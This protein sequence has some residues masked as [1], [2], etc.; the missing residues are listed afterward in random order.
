[1]K[2]SYS[3]GMAF[4]L[5][6]FGSIGIATLLTSV[7]T[8]RIYGVT[9]VGQ[10]ALAL[11]PVMVVTLLSTVREQPAMVRK[12]AKLEPR[13]PAVTGIWLAVFCFSFALT[14]VVAALGVVACWFV[15][16]GPI[17]EPQLFAPAAVALAGYLLVINTCWNV[18][19]AL[20]AFRAGREL[21]EVRLHQALMYGALV[22]AFSFVDEG[23]WSLTLA[24]LVSWATSLVHRCALVPRVMRLRVPRAQLREGFAELREIVGFGLKITP[25]SIANGLSDASGTWI[26]GVTSSV[27]AVGAFSRAWNVS[28]RFGEL[29][30]RVT[31]M[32]LP[33]L[34]ERRA[35]GD[36]EGTHRVVGDSLRY[37][38]FGML[39]P[40]AVG[41]GAAHAV[42]QLFGSGFAPAASALCWLLL[43]PWLQTM[44]A[45]QGSVLMAYNRPVWT[46]FAQG[47]RLL[48]TLTA[49][50][51]LTLAIG[52]T[53][54][55]VAIVGGCLASFGV[56]LVI[57]RTLAVLPPPPL[58]RLARLLAGIG[59]A[60]AAGFFGARTIE[61]H[62][63]WPL[64]LPLALLGGTAAF[65]LAALAVAG[66][67]ARDRE[68]L[69]ALWRL[70][71][72]R[73]ADRR[74]RGGSLRSNAAAGAEDVAQ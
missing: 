5:A 3:S 40:A 10:A 62:V 49:G 28:S 51:L 2:R 13:D 26:L 69:R 35:A 29:N 7:L 50:I 27:A 52:L 12:I 18:D 72:A 19:G 58:A 24:F 30:W 60:Y 11:A 31:E 43:A 67:T 6:S 48:V 56:Y 57:M 66:L 39:L 20:G 34:V 36:V 9:V 45:I 41:G 71:R 4:A 70:L 64:Q 44:T 25:G 15:F 33:T 38:A 42:M 21:F 68:R 16:H 46:S 55:G 47:A 53:G 37:A 74:G 1:M 54:M 22:V 23:V 65:V 14:A 73:R 59:A 32:L 61:Q 17:D 8:A 63:A